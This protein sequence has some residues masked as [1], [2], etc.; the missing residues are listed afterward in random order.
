MNRDDRTFL[1]TCFQ[2]DGEVRPGLAIFGDDKRPDSKMATNFGDDRRL[3]NQTGKISLTNRSGL[4]TLGR[5]DHI[6]SP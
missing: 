2:D 1:K 3:C 4:V 5:D 6:E